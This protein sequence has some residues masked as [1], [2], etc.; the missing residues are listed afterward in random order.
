MPW[1]LL[2][3]L[4][5]PALCPACG[6]RV[7]IEGAVFA[8]DV[9]GAPRRWH[10]QCRHDEHAAQGAKRERREQAAAR[11]A[12]VYRKPTLVRETSIAALASIDAGTLRDIVYTAI[13]DAGDAT[14]DEL[15]IKLGLTHQTT[16]ARVHELMKGHHIIDSG[17]RRP[18]RS[19]RAATV[20]RSS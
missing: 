14:C 4:P 16:S 11:R 9:A 18:T 5:P 6:K 15:E 12:T 1:Q 2:F 20:W 8:D 19:G 10:R 7:P 3:A 13:V 17:A